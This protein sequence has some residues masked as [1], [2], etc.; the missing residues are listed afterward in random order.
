MS[1][2]GG[3]W[4]IISSWAEKQSWDSNT[5]ASRALKFYL[6]EQL[7]GARSSDFHKPPTRSE[8]DKV[9]RPHGAK[10]TRSFDLFHSF[11][12]EVLSRLKFNGSDRSNRHVRLLRTETTADAVTIPTGLVGDYRRGVDESGSLYTPSTLPSAPEPG[13]LLSSLTRG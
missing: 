8:F 4:S 1:T 11:V 9:Q 7:D 10:Y 6:M 5:E 2:Q 13:P 3:D 12:Q